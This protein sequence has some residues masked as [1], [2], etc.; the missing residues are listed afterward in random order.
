[1]LPAQADFNPWRMVQIAAQAVS[2]ERME[3]DLDHS[4]YREEGERPEDANEVVVVRVKPP[5]YFSKTCWT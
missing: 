1:M 3:G 4:S 5:C 2:F